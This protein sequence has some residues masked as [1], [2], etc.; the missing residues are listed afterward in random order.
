MCGPSSALKAINANIQD[1]AKT[2]QSE[3]G[4]IFADA[5]SVFHKIMGGI[6]GIL[7]GGPSQFGESAGELSATNAAIM[8]AGAAEARNLKGAAAATV[9]AI[10]GG[11][12]VAPAG[13]TQA[14][15]LSAEQKAAEDTATAKNL[16]LQRGFEIGRENFQNAE[17]V[18]LNA[19]SVFN[20]ATEANRN[21]SDAQK[22]A[23]TS[24]QNIDTQSNWAMNDVMKLGTAAV[25]GFA[26]GGFKL[27]SFGGGGGG[28]SGL[29]S[30]NTSEPVYGVG[31]DVNTNG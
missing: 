2:V 30:L 4:D 10:G 21:V 16:N 12:V 6:D 23:M 18:A 31:P 24:Q 11:N 15:V 3:A 27:P 14:T 25:S 13:A 5:S 7:T 19:P 20:P 1:F 9:G 28:D 17:K 8:E 29:A 22:N 26:S